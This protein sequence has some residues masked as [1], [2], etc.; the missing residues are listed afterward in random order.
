MTGRNVSEMWGESTT[1]VNMFAP[2]LWT[3]VSL[4]IDPCTRM[5]MHLFAAHQQ[6]RTSIVSYAFDLG[7]PAHE[8]EL[9]SIANDQLFVVI[10]SKLINE[11][12][13]LFSNL[14]QYMMH[15]WWIYIKQGPFTFQT[16]SKKGDILFVYLLNSSSE[17][18]IFWVYLCSVKVAVSLQLPE[19]KSKSYIAAQ[20]NCW[21]G[22]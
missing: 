10:D 4:A 17:S 12:V 14:T 22:K 13:F 8:S 16:W 5:Q 15:R 20:P 21:S 3:R 11:V 2:D 19:Q 18:R 9:R 1:C 6:Y 7:T